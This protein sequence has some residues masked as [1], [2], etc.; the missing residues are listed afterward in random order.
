MSLPMSKFSLFTN[1]ME[2]LDI[3]LPTDTKE[4]KLKELCEQHLYHCLSSYTSIPLA[5]EMS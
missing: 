4:W 3:T 2:S 1:G 5:K